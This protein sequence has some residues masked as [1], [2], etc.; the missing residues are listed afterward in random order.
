MEDVYSV[1]GRMY[2]DM[3]NMQKVIEL[4]QKQLKEKDQQ[5]QDNIVRDKDE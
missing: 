5:N 1:I 2:V 4:L 3:Y